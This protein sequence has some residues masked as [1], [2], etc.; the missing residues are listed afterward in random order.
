MRPGAVARFLGE[1][2]YLNS[3]VRATVGDLFAAWTS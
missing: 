3:N 2:C 1:R